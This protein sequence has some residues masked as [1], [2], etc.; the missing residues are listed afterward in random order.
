MTY[1][2]KSDLAIRRALVTACSKVGSWDH[3]PKFVK[4]HFRRTPTHQGPT[5]P[6]RQYGLC[7]FHTASLMPVK[8]RLSELGF[9]KAEHVT[10]VRLRRVRCETGTYR[11]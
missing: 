2:L 4:S 11:A 8:S 1:A 10:N 5:A 7:T 6:S 3:S 9:A